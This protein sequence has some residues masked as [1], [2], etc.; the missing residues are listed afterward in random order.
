METPLLIKPKPLRTIA[1]KPFAA[2]AGKLRKEKGG[3]Y[4]CEEE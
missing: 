3:L 2:A 1:A 4:V